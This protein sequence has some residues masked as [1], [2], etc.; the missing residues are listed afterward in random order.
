MN[1]TESTAPTSSSSV[2][3]AT[4][5]AVVVFGTL[6]LIMVSLKYIISGFKSLMR[7]TKYQNIGTSSKIRLI[8]QLKIAISELSEKKIGALITI[9]NKDSIDDLR[10][11][12]IIV[13]CNISSAILLSIFNKHSPLHDG[14]IVI[15][16]SRIKYVATYYKISSKHV[17]NKYGARHRAAIG[18]SEQCDALTIVVSEE[19]GKIS[20]AKNG[21]LKTIKFP[22]FEQRIIPELM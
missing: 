1:I 9:V 2:F 3:D 4:F 18:I 12:G 16:G 21:V 8:H 13:D 19:T 22:E 11:D 5:I 17:N 20:F 6:I 10:T 7:R 14:A 15:D